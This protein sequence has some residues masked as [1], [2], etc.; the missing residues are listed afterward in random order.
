MH[1]KTDMIELIIRHHGPMTD[2]QL[3]RWA[4]FF[5]ITPQ[6]A[7][8]ARH[9]LCRRRRVATTAERIVRHRTRF[10]RRKLWHAT[11]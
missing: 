3:V 5:G 9:E 1:T 11:M 7:R 2:E 4:G 8:R 6:T 10:T